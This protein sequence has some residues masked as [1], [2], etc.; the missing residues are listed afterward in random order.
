VKSGAVTEPLRVPYDIVDGVVQ[1]RWI[2]AAGLRDLSASSGYWTLVYSDNEGAT[3][4]V[5]EFGTGG[6]GEVDYFKKSLRGFQVGRQIM[7]S[8]NGIRWCL[9]A[10]S[11]LG[12]VGE[13]MRLPD[14][15]WDNYSTVDSWANNADGD[16]SHATFG[17]DRPSDG[18]FVGVDTLT[19]DIGNTDGTFTEWTWENLNYYDSLPATGVAPGGINIDNGLTMNWLENQSR[20]GDG[21]FPEFPAERVEVI[22]YG[23]F[24]LGGEPPP[25][26]PWPPPVPP[27]LHI[28]YKRWLVDPTAIWMQEQNWLTVERWAREFLSPDG[29]RPC[30]GMTGTPPPS[31]CLFHVPDPRAVST[32]GRE[33]NWSEMES[34]VSRILPGCLCHD[35]DGTVTPYWPAGAN[36]H[37]P[38]HRVLSVDQEEQNWLA[39]ERWVDQLKLTACEGT[40]P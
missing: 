28:P 9:T 35:C 39:L 5:P 4:Y 15:E 6:V 16:G 33:D 32:R 22:A 12:Q 13:Y 27:P 3:W 31:K 2:V 11:I 14:G 7:F 29:C 1:F 8:Q 38:Y 37:V 19:E 23:P 40:A 25:Q 20:K 26:D 24:V 21:C 10:P 30:S 36:L 17:I 34:W 18:F